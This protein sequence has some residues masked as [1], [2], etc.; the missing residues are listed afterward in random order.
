MKTRTH[1]I[2]GLFVL[3]AVLVSGGCVTDFLHGDSHRRTDRSSGS[4][5][6]GAHA[7]AGGG[8]TDLD[9]P[10]AFAP[11]GGQ[12]KCRKTSCEC[13]DEY[14]D[15]ISSVCIAAAYSDPGWDCSG[16]CKD[17]GWCST[18][19]S[20]EQCGLYSYTFNPADTV[21][22]LEQSCNAAVARDK[23]CGT[24]SV[25]D[26]CPTVATVESVEMIAAYE[27]IAQTPCDKPVDTCNPSWT[28]LGDEVCGLVET[29]CYTEACR[30]EWRTVLNG[31]G[32]WLR[33]ATIEAARACLQQDQCA[34]IMDCLDA[35]K[36]AV[37][38]GGSLVDVYPFRSD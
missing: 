38:K 8:A 23:R 2:N 10:V 5:G 19:S 3:A 35:W 27:C 37:Y 32:G 36:Q 25:I 34:N 20:T 12:R 29:M 26:N 16:A 11:L 18:C 33:P 21:P 4:A 22:E 31:T 17:D 13:A 9:A 6:A 24:T 1:S 7:G 15:C 30:P 14:D 28:T